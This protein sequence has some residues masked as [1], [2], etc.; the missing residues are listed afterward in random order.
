MF[1]R[2]SI[3]AVAALALCGT[4][5]MAIHASAADDLRALLAK[6]ADYVGKPQGAVLTY[7][8]ESPQAAPASVPHADLGPAQEKT[9]RRAGLFHTIRRAEGV[10]FESGFD[11]RA[12]WTS[13][14]NGYTVTERGEAARR[15]ITRNAV[16]A[17]VF[18]ESTE[19]RERG[20]QTVDGK[21]AVVLRVTPHG[22]VPADVALDPVTGG[23]VAVTFEPDDRYARSTRHYFGYEEIAPGVRVPAAYRND[24]G[25]RYRL[26]ENRVRPVTDE[27][28]RAPAPA[29]HWSFA[30]ETLPI[31][32]EGSRKDLRSVYVHASIDGHPGKFLLDTGASQIVL[33]H[34]YVEKLGLAMLGDTAFSGVAGRTQSARYARAQRIVFGAATL[35]NVVVTVAA[36]DG[37]FAG[38]RSRGIDGIIGYDALAGAVVHVDLIHQTIAFGDPAA[39]EPVLG[40]DAFAFPVNLADETP[41]VA[42][43]LGNVTTR[44]TIDTGNSGWIALSDNLHSSGRLV[45][46][47]GP[48]SYSVGV[49]GLADEPDPCYRLHEVAVGPYRYQN[50]FVCLGKERVFGRDGGLIGLDF[51]HHFNWTFDYARSRVVLTPNGL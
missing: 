46:L 11:R 43:E 35:S 14:P 47:G 32:I 23:Y 41:E 44:A 4:A 30:D 48:V 39:V 36:D 16:D 22:G 51:L 5:G 12:Y 45:A 26:V 29:P 50:S 37:A 1:H 33:Y 17:G 24:D 34:P 9:Y 18:P 40:K 15:A 42:V 3:A 49:D 8:V 19:V 21:N 20:T 2:V 27:E 7:R 6:H 38:F 13:N 25:D 10:S 28:L 31:E